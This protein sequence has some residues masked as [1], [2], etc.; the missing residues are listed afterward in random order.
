MPS[1]IPKKSKDSDH[2]EA[3]VNDLILFSIYSVLSDNEICSFDRIVKECFTLFPKSFS[4]SR[5]PLWPDSRKLDRPLRALRN[6][7]LIK[8]DPKIEFF[9]TKE[10]KERA[11]AVRK[12]LR[13]G[14]L[15]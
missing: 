7:K 8:G 1:L 14:K 13:Q 10:G 4:F 11:E 6:A 12:S 9:L 5:Y 3:S 15:L 2:E